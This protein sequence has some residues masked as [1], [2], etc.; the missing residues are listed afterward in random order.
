M[1]ILGIAED[2]TDLKKT[3][4]QLDL[5]RYAVEQSPASV[6]ITD[7][8]GIIQYV[9]TKFCAVTGYT[10]QEAIGN[11]P[12]ILKSGEKP[13][14]E[15][16]ELWEMLTSGKVWS[17]EFHNKKKDGSLYWEYASISPIVSSSGEITHYLA[18]K[19]DITDRK[20][21]EEAL[22]ERKNELE[23]LNRIMVDR[24]LRMI[25]LKQQLAE[26]QAKLAV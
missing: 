13:P 15:Y 1:S 6:V 20:N 8:K 10:S 21:A 11:N 24:E 4:Q 23:R 16:K 26:L 17:G 14:E 12:R 22:L 25:E 3:E 2:I 7:I 19:E 9:N 18:V 5:F